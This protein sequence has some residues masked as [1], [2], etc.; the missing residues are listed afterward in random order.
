MPWSP[1][2]SIEEKLK[3]LVVPA[4]LY[5]RYLYGKELRKGERE[6]RLVPFLANKGRVSLDIGANK[7]VYAYALLGHSAAVHGFEPNPKM[8]RVLE[9]WAR[10]R[11]HLH[12]VALGDASGTADL[13]IPRSRH[14][15]SNQ[16][17]SLSQARMEGETCGI[18]SVDVLRLDD[19]GIAN[20]GFMKIDV[21]GF[22]CQV[23]AGARETLRR[24]RPNLLVEIEE[25][26]AKR[27]LP[28][29]IAEICAYDYRCLVLCGGTLMPFERYCNR[30]ELDD[31]YVFNFIFLP[32]EGRGLPV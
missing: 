17:G 5:I 13:L 10:D 32:A 16:G 21:E 4:G 20:V 15:Y 3:R 8:F 28:D 30:T 24:D 12:A 18:V 22:E 1:P 25:R 29:M 31:G 19:L 23:L 26:H 9:S 7:G 27:P 11:V 2:E 14:G 6:I